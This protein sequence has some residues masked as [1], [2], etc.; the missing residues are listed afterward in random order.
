[1][2]V[3]EGTETY[4]D[5]CVKL[6]VKNVE[7]HGSAINLNCVYDVHICMCVYMYVYTVYERVN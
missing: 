1:M 5:N 3:F 6:F 2:T 7:V 4:L